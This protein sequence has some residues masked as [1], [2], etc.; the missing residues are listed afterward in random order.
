MIIGRR[1]NVMWYENETMQSP[2]DVAKI[3][4]QRG[5]LFLPA[6][7]DYFFIT[8]NAFPWHLVLA[9]MVVARPGY[10]NFLVAT[11]IMNN[12]SVVDATATVLAVHMT[13]AEGNWAG[14]HSSKFRDMNFNKRLIGSF[15]YS[16]GY[17]SSA[18][19]A[20]KTVKNVTDN[21]T[22]ISV[23]KRSPMI[24]NRK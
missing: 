20:T 4:K 18:Q 22:Y 21:S 16:R 11:A 24:K 13:D 6:A 15:L 12:M 23:K 9:D 1:T 3:A 17:T 8:M 19:Y 10:D 5:R 2:D 14:E 7:E